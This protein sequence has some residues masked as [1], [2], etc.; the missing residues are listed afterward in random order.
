VAIARRGQ[1]RD[2][3]R[4]PRR[5]LSEAQL[6]DFLE[7]R[8]FQEHAEAQ[9]KWHRLQVSHD[10]LS[11]YFVGLDAIQQARATTRDR[12]DLAAFNKRLLDIGDVEPRFIAS[13]I[14]TPAR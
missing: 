7:H 5:L 9:T 12:Y 11:S 2:R 8:A 6:Y 13:L 10:Q 3:R 14:A 4:V 1:R